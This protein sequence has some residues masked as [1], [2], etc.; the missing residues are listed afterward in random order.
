LEDYLMQSSIQSS[1][2]Q[3]NF[4]QVLDRAL[5]EGAVVVERYGVPR[6]AIVEYGRYQ[7]L[8]AAERE[9]LRARLQDAARAAS[10]RA[11][12]LSDEE[13]DSL[14]EEARRDVATQGRGA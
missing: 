13:V 14:I 2:A 4:G 1:H 10:T 11:A 12:A 6:V 7:R 3:Q 8:V 5:V 9:L